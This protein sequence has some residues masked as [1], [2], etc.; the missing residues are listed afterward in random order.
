MTKETSSLLRHPLRLALILALL[1]GAGFLAARNTEADHVSPFINLT[2]ADNVVNHNGAKFVQGGIG[3]G[4]GN[5]DP[6]LTL[7][8]GGN[9]PQEQ[10]YNT[11]AAGGEFETFF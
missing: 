1:A 11:T 5:F 2:I 8:A 9:T 7:N 10:G 3:A 6:F 4:T